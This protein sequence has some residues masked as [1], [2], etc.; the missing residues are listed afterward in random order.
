MGKV[1]NL[2][3]YKYNKVVD[4]YCI[5]LKK[6]RE[7]KCIRYLYNMNLKPSLTCAFYNR[8]CPAVTVLAHLKDDPLTINDMIE[9]CI[10]KLS[11]N[12]QDLIVYLG[13]DMLKL[14]DEEFNELQDCFKT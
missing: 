11:I 9:Q 3:K 14:A 12:K 13:E 4:Y 10:N 1:I 2:E 6:C 8:D 5:D 7:S